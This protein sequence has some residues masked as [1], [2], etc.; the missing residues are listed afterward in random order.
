MI[1]EKASISVCIVNWNTRD[2]L[3]C[4]LES[5]STCK[6]AAQVIV[7]DNN[8]SDGS[9][10][11]VRRHFSK[12]TLILGGENLG[13]ARGNNLCFER[14][15]GEYILIANPDIILTDAALQALCQPFSRGSRIGAVGAR[16]INEDGSAQKHMCRKFPSLLQ[17]LLY[18]TILKYLFLNWKWL[19]YK[20]WED[21]TE[22]E[23]ISPVD[24]PA[25]A[26]LMLRRD[27][28]DRMGGFDSSFDLFYED[29]DL[30]RRLQ[31]AGYLIVLN[32]MARVVHRGS[33][34]LERELP[35]RIKRL[36]YQSGALYFALHHGPIS[37][38]LYR[39]IFLSNE[40][41]K[42]VV[43]LAMVPFLRRKRAILKGN[44]GD[45]LTFIGHVI[46]GKKTEIDECA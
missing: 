11:M 28:L 37:S 30:C 46:S 25:G 20:I 22:V 41:V 4:L 2:D 34:S 13:F 12:A 26:C 29:V 5:L 7:C 32:P 42:I 21:D 44:I 31:K 10:D 39:L 14:C 23:Q 19:R 36:Y 24:Q 9:A 17:I 18:E 15:R 3:R 6:T 16:L 33:T 27:A 40:A 45:S 35:L 8:S 38:F 1:D 43:R